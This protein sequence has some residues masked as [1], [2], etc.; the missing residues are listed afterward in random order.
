MPHARQQPS[1]RKQIF[2]LGGIE[3]NHPQVIASGFEVASHCNH[4][5][6]LS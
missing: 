6:Q 2:T 3:F 1:E 4:N 5:G